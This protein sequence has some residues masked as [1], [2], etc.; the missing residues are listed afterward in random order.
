MR[1]QTFFGLICLLA[2]GMLGPLAGLAAAQEAA[3]DKTLLEIEILMAPVGSDPLLAQQWRQVFEELGEGVRIRPPLGSDQVA[4]R[5]LTRGPFRVVRVTGELT[6]T[7]ELRFPGKRFQRT[8]TSKLQEWLGELKTYGAQGSPSGQ[9]LWGLSQEQ[10]EGVQ[11]ALAVP[12]ATPLRGKTLGDVVEALP[13]AKAGGIRVHSSAEE[14]MALARSQ[15]VEEE[16]QGLTTGTALAYA[17]LQ[18]GLAFRPQRLPQGNVELL[19]LP[20]GEAADRW[21]VGWPADESIPRDQIVPGLFEKVQ[22]G[23]QSAPLAAVIE[24][25]EEKSGVRV[26]VDHRGCGAKGIDLQAKLVSYPPRH[27]AWALIL[28]TVAHGAHLTVDYRQDEAGTGFVYVAPFAS[29]TPRPAV[30]DSAPTP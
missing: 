27:T 7:G 3:A 20:A 30:N 29:Y 17:L 25:V 6:R 16:L 12:V 21:P 19:I 13:L 26:L 2:G 28:K 24:A 9:P 22:T 10:Y 14:Q 1:R 5:E 4:I 8:D 15:P 18:E 23:I 11:Q